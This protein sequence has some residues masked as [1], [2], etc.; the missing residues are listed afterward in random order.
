MMDYTQNKEFMKILTELSGE[1]EGLNYSVKR[2]YSGYS[3]VIKQ[4]KESVNTN[5]EKLKRLLA[6]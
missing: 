4:R 2:G 5:V 3:E 6:E 1:V